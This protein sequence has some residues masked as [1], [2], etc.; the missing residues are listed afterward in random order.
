MKPIQNQYQDLLEGKMFKH[1]FLN[2]VKNALPEYVSKGNSYEDAISILKSKRIISENKVDTQYQDPD[3]LAKAIASKYPELQ[4]LALEDKKMFEEAAF[5][6]AVKLMKS[7][8][9]SSTVRTNLINGYSDEDWPSDFISALSDALKSSA[10]SELKEI[11]SSR[12]IPNTKY[13][14]TGGAETAILDYIGKREDNPD[15]K[16]GSS[17]GKGHIFQWPDGK[18]F[19]LGPISVMKY[20]SKIE[21]SDEDEEIIN[22]YDREQEKHALPGGHTLENKNSFD[23]VLNRLS[24]GTATLNKFTN[25]IDAVNPIEYRNGVS[26]EVD[27]GGDF[28][29]EGL[30][31]AVKKVLKNLKKDPIYYTNLKAEAT[32]KINN[33]KVVSSEY[34]EL[35]KDNQIDKLNQL[36]SI[37]KKEI[38]NTKTSLSKQEKASKAMPKGVKLMKEDKENNT[39]LLDNIKSLI[40]PE[41]LENSSIGYS[42]K[43]GKEVGIIYK[44]YKELP[45][46]DMVKLQDKYIV[47][48][49][50][51]SSEDEPITVQYY[52]SPKTSEPISQNKP[53]R[54]PLP[55]DNIPI[56]DIFENDDKARQEKDFSNFSKKM[57]GKK[58]SAQNTIKTK[59]KE[60]VVKHLKKEA[61][62]F[63]IGASGDKVYKPETGVRAYEDELKAAGVKFTKTKA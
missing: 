46:S 31:N 13:E 60:Y 7:A 57:I 25:E 22:R 51:H 45:Y 24:E 39:K 28:S 23:K 20:I 4:K 15:I 38:A 35:K 32:K 26:Y 41:T 58:S 3:T 55:N 50:V 53:V 5:K 59:I 36:K 54:K 48:K 14:Y 9:L 62:K 21:D 30:Q 63:T 29:G 6:Y 1:N 34:T 44:S 12:L 37:V 33:K 52:I 8:G 56:E 17:M 18:Y 42:D 19:E 47:F 2:N 16:V 43:K 11:T 10:V 61:V 40:S 27:L 49:D